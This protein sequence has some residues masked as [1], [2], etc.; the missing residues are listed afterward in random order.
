[1]DRAQALALIREYVK[2]ESVVKHVIAVEAVMRGLAKRLGADE[3]LWG[4]TGLLHDI[5]FDLTTGSPEKHGIV[6]EGILRNLVP[7]GVL[8]AIKAHNK[9]TGVEPL[10]LMEKALVASD[11]AS[12]L[13]VA[14]ALVM[15][16][17]KLEEVR[18]ETVARKFK[19]RDFAR[20]ADRERMLLAQELGLTMEEFFAI[21]LEALKRVSRELGL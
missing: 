14:C 5:D 1:V 8:R 10:S 17:K 19:D 3:D 4:A 13:I 7:E 6:A 12:G 18:P 11:G 21:S 16:S 20:G 9:R 15:P 2:R